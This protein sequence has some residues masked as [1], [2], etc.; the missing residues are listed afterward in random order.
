MN[1]KDNI[2]FYV[3]QG[4]DKYEKTIKNLFIDNYKEKIIDGDTK[5]I[6]M[7]Y[8]SKDLKKAI[9]ERKMK[10]IDKSRFLSEQ[11]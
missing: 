8:Y 4:F 5:C 3:K 10:S 1:G 9:H 7:Y 2:P 6:D 11:Y